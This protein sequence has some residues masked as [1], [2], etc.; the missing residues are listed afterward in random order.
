MSQDI[1]PQRQKISTG[2]A[3]K[4]DGQIL[5]E[6]CFELLHITP[7]QLG[8]LPADQVQFAIQW[9]SRRGQNLKDEMEYSKWKGENKL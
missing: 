3:A 4:P 7:E 1:A 8:R 5:G 6:I 2:F 9:A